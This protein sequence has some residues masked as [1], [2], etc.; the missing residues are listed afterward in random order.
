MTR[1]YRLAMLACGVPATL[2]V[3]VLAAHAGQGEFYVLDGFGGVHAGGG[4]PVISPSTPYFG[5]DIARDIAYVPRGDAGGAGNG[6][7]VLDGF[8]GV[9]D[10]GALASAPVTPKTPYFGFDI[11]RAIVSRNVPP[12][13]VGASPE[14][15]GDIADNGTTVYTLVSA[16][17]FAPD[18]GF[19]VV[20][21]SVN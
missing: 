1:R 8:G 18:D 20:L 14:T 9:H 5:F 15:T 4:A 11:A 13:V 19:L 16:S 21:G 12:R 17:I 6:V 7:L 2:L 3:A 10:G